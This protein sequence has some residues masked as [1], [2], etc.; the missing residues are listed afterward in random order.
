MPTRCLLSL[1]RRLG[2]IPEDTLFNRRAAEFTR[3]AVQAESNRRFR[4][5]KR[6]EREASGPTG[7]ESS[8]SPIV[9][10]LDRGPCPRQP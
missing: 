8:P 4:E 9:N 6:A 2:L 1:Y 10:G 5:R 7:E 3:W